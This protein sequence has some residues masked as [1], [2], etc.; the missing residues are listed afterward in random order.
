MS[1]GIDQLKKMLFK[2]LEALQNKDNPMDI[3]RAKA[4]NET[5]QVLINAA[6]AEIEFAKVNGSVDS[7]F[8]YKK[9]LETTPNEDEDPGNLLP[10]SSVSNL[11]K[12]EVKTGTLEIEGNV[13]RH[14]AK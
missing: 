10:K 3:D 2:T 11:I 4:I 5:S 9:A 6:K 12:K 13:T 14:I 1:Q 8:F 7:V